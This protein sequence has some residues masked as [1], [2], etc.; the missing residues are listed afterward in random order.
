MRDDM[1]SGGD[2]NGSDKKLKEDASK[3]EVLG[4]GFSVELPQEHS[5]RLV[6]NHDLKVQLPSE[7]LFVRVDQLGTGV[8]YFQPIGTHSSSNYFAPISLPSNVFQPTQWDS[9]WFKGKASSL[10]SGEADQLIGSFLIAILQFLA[11]IFL[12]KRFRGRTMYSNEH[13]K[14]NRLAL[15]V[16]R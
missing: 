10:A 4:E 6:H 1:F 15:K 9:F 2:G 11:T 5:A 3:N 13:T 8:N 14:Q 7:E 12:G 16:K